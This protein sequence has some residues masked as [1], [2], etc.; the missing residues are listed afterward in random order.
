MG[1]YRAQNAGD[2]DV[3]VSLADFD[4]R[5]IRLPED[6]AALLECHC[7]LIYESDAPWAREAPY[8][9]YREKWLST[10]QPDQFLTSLERSLADA[11]T[12]ADLWWDGGEAVA[13]LWVVF[14]EFGGYGMSYGEV[15]EIWV[16]HARRRQGLGV[17]L[18]RLAEAAAREAGAAVLR[19][20]AGAEN[21]ASQ[22][23]VMRQ[24]FSSIQVTFEKRVTPD[25]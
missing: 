25:G 9:R 7:E 17:Q 19:W 2:R 23:L 22:E 5:Q 3:T 24:G 20:T 13:Y 16:A 6:R 11:S 21:K 4:R 18:V 8:E 12:I 10:P 15:N 14:G 1:E